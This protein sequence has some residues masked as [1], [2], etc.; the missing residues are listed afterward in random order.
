GCF[1]RR[2]STS[3][4]RSVRGRSLLSL[5]ERG[6]S[7]CWP[8]RLE[9]LGRGPLGR[10]R[11]R[12]LAS[13]R[14]LPKRLAFGSSITSISASSRWT[15][16]WANARSIASSTV[17]PVVSTHSM[18]YRAFLLR[19]AFERGWLWGLGVGRGWLFD[20]LFGREGC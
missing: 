12:T 15:P 6:R 20:R 9:R 16:R 17:F 14:T 10:T 1:P 2:A 18:G 3:G 7:P 19:F 8:E 11:A 5:A 4:R 13:P